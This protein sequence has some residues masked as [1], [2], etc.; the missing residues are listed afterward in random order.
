M[1][2]QGPTQLRAKAAGRRSVSLNLAGPAAELAARPEASP[3][4]AAEAAASASAPSTEDSEGDSALTE[5][6]S[7]KRKHAAKKGAPPL[8]PHGI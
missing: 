1:Q 2:A 7:K 4:P 6:G 8:P 3:R 5:G